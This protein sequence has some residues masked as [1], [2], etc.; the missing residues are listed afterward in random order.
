MELFTG[1]DRTRFPLRLKMQLAAIA[2]FI[3]VVVGLN[4]LRKGSLPL[5]DDFPIAF[6]NS[7]FLAMASSDQVTF[8]H[9]C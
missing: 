8:K 7:R 5:P 4:E 3:E 6:G 1:T 9:I 2:F